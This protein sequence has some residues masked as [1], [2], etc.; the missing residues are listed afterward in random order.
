MAGA[1]RVLHYV[2]MR[3]LSDQLQWTGNEMVYLAPFGHLAFFA[4]AALPLSAIALFAP[5]WLST[6]VLT[7]LFAT[8]AVF[9]F[10]LLFPRIHHLASLALA[11][12]AGLQIG[13]MTSRAPVRSAVVLKRLGGGI[14]A[15][16]VLAAIAVPIAFRSIEARKIRAL[17]RA[18]SDAPNVL[19]VVL[20]ATR[21]KNM[22]VYGYQR[23]T[24]PNIERLGAEG[25][26]FDRAISTTS[27]TLPSVASMMTGYYPTSLSTDWLTPLDHKFPVLAERLGARGYL[28]GAFSANLN[29][30]TRE[31]GLSR[32]FTRFLDVRPSVMEMLLTVSLVQSDLVGDARLALRSRDAMGLLRA[33]GRFHWARSTS[34]PTHQPKS[35][36][37]L[38]QEFL[39]W[40][41]EARGR[42][43]FAIMQF[44]D[45][46]APYKP[47][48][49]FDTLFASS[50]ATAKYD[51]AIA[52]IDN[53]LGALFAELS[54]RGA[55]ERTHVIVTA[56]HGELFGEHGLWE[57]GN[58]LYMPLINVPL[59]IRAP[60][61]MPPGVRVRRPVSLRDL[62]STILD[63]VDSTRSDE[64]ELGGESLRSTWDST[65]GG[66]PSVAASALS[67]M[68]WRRS[69]D[70]IRWRL[71]SLVDDS[72]HY[73]KR[74]DGDDLL[75]DMHGDP[76]E[77][78][79]LSKAP[80]GRAR[81]DSLRL[82][83]EAAVKPEQRP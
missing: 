32:G 19:L 16:S 56:D 29:Y 38:V 76:D 1:A 79:S 80:A 35:S 8:L 26:V 24:T 55:F 82:K 6:R 3:L 49:P 7:V 40:Q 9:S 5:R 70:P 58:G 48:P 65:T 75:F 63:L 10:M 23:R 43:W 2:V 66:R 17:P 21:A 22:S 74:V 64:P 60:G 71:T 45:A 41:L 36:A 25:V 52:T 42:P 30:V 46:H 62:A 68:E 57:H 31:T 53:D 59:I 14:L 51:G 77:S 33:L 73:I 13:R 15:A 28:T 37:V 39:D 61:R 11:I 47:R 4:V 20:D 18:A 12:G 44:I 50:A 34:T 72:L 27:W 54:R 83:L 78:L 69:S 81:A 67:A